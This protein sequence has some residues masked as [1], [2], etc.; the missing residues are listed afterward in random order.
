MPQGSFRW[1]QTPSCGRRWFTAAPTP[2]PCP[3]CGAHVKD[4]T[5]GWP[6]VCSRGHGAQ[7]GGECQECVEQGAT[8]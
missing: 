2:Q 8:P 5:D 1:C 6:H 4:A 3:F 7:H